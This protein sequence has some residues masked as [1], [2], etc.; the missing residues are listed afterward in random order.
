MKA[1]ITGITGQDG[2]YLAEF[3]LSRGYEVHGTVRHSSGEQFERI[4]HIIDR[5]HIH[6]ADLL[7]QLSIIHLIEEI[8]PDEVYNLAAYLPPTGGWHQPITCSLLNAQ[9]VIRILEA[10]RLIDLKIGFF[11]AS[12]AAMFGQPAESPQNEQTPFYPDSPYGAAKLYAH[13]TTVNYRNRY[14]VK[15]CSGILFDH[16]SPRRSL[17]FITRRITH[18]AARIKLGLQ[19][20]LILDTLD[21]NRDWGFAGD[22]VRSFWMMLQ[23]PTPDD[24]VIAS[25]KTHSLEDFCRAAFAAANLDWRDYVVIENPFNRPT[26]SYPLK[27]DTSRARRKLLWEPEI[28]FE[29]T[30]KMMVEADM[31]RHSFTN[32]LRAD[33]EREEK[34]RWSLSR[35]GMKTK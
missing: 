31:A 34:H 4:S 9:V 6:Q 33:L 17:E 19:D 26:K 20:K 12:T 16:E 7:D 27:G 5:L 8:R 25:G 18:A 15:T 14:G 11:Q 3:L 29:E 22:Y 28:S 1:I 30:I 35:Q 10:I 23:Q 13:W 24:Y 32:R 21:V 2:S